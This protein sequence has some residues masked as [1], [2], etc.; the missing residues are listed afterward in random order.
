[1]RRFSLF[2]ALAPLL[3]LSFSLRAE[4]THSIGL[5]AHY[6][7]VIDDIDVD[8][9]EES[10]LAYL[11]AYRIDGGLIAFQGELEVFPEDFGGATERVYSPQA[12]VL[13]GGGIY[14]GLGVGV[15]YSDGEFADKP[16]YLVR[17]GIELAAFGPVSLDINANY[18]F[19]DFDSFDT[20]DIDTDTVTL[21]A[22]VRVEL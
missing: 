17:A 7:R 12:L 15:L 13:V 21:G 14:A 16:Y 22:M 8:N 11:G 3:A 10:G 6:W 4:T 9:V 1:M 2:L 18:L 19:N 5:G 20:S